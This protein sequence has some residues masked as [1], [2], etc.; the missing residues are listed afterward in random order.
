MVKSFIIREFLNSVRAQVKAAEIANEGI[1]AEYLSGAGSR[2]TLD[3]IQ[4][5]SLLLNAQIS[6]ANSEKKLPTSPIQ[7]F[8]ISWS[9]N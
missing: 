8:K 4:S 1:T 2:S 7:P 9:I 5:N 6:L 3:L